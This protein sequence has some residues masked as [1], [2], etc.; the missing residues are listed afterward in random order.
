MKKIRVYFSGSV[1]IDAK[2][3][4]LMNL[5]TEKTETAAEIL[6]RG[7]TI[8]GQNLIIKSFAETYEKALDE[9]FEQLNYWE[10][11]EE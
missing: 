11:V 7:E 1:E 2:D 10:I 5:E 6:A 3:F 9:E 4:K 8:Y